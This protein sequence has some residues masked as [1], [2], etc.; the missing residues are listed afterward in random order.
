M[1]NEHSDV[2]DSNHSPWGMST[3]VINYMFPASAA[4]DNDNILQNV[5]DED[6]YV[7][8]TL[9][10]PPPGTSIFDYLNENS[11]EEVPSEKNMTK[12]QKNEKDRKLGS[13]LLIHRRNECSI[14]LDEITEGQTISWSS[15]DCEHVFHQQCILNWLMTLGRKSIASANVNVRNV[16]SYD[17]RCPNCRQNFIQNAAG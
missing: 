12:K 8:A 3:K 13:N 9:K 15:L 16:C 10:L 7:N 5:K 4:K 2:G 1:S 6:Q 11:D 14:C 17:M